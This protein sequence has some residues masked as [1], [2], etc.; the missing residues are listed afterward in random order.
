MYQVFN[1][2][3]YGNGRY[4]DDLHMTLNSLLEVAQITS[5]VEVTFSRLLISLYS[6]SLRWDNLVSDLMARSMGLIHNMTC[7]SWTGKENHTFRSPVLLRV[8]RRHPYPVKAAN[9]ETFI[10]NTHFASSR[11]RILCTHSSSDLCNVRPSLQNL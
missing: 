4:I 2:S 10:I 5:N 9:V 3:F 8:H 1:G 6:L 7:L 11:D